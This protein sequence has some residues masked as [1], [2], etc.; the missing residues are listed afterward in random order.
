MDAPSELHFGAVELT[1]LAVLQHTAAPDDLARIRA[2][3][4]DLCENTD[5]TAQERE[6]FERV[7]SEAVQQGIQQRTRQ[8]TARSNTG[9]SCTEHFVIRQAS[10]RL[11]PTAIVSAGGHSSNS[12]G[13]LALVASSV[14]LEWSCAELTSSLSLAELLHH[15]MEYVALRMAK[16]CRR[17]PKN[18]SPV[19]WLGYTEWKSLRFFDRA[20]VVLAAKEYEQYICDVV[21]AR[22]NGLGAIGV[23]ARVS[24]MGVTFL[25]RLVVPA[26]TLEARRSFTSPRAWATDM[27]PVSLRGKLGAAGFRRARSRGG[28]REGREVGAIKNR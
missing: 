2:H 26:L 20:Q 1:R 7:C 16:A 23:P 8:L 5:I 14:S 24:K 12:W 28:G 19:V 3:W 18:S 6:Q 9:K 10:P 21:H 11:S 4:E 17:N 25:R 13:I 22:Q 27:L 15:Y